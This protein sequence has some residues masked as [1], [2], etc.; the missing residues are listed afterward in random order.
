MLKGKQGDDIVAKPQII[1]VPPKSKVPISPTALTLGQSYHEG[2]RQNKVQEQ[3]ERK[4]KKR[5]SNLEILKVKISEQSLRTQEK[6]GTPALISG[7]NILF[8]IQ[9]QDNHNPLKSIQAP[10]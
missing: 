7:H 5:D 2:I 4:R 10:G 3:K 8:C 1:S 9:F 6:L